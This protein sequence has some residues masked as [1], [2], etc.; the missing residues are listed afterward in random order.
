[1]VT[2]PHFGTIC[3]YCTSPHFNYN[4]KQQL[5]TYLP[6]DLKATALARVGPPRQSAGKIMLSGRWLGVME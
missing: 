6:Q 3:N 1:M 2:Q 5:I 4:E